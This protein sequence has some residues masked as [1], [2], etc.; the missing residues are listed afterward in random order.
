MESITPLLTYAL[1]LSIAAVI[2]GPGIAALVGQSLGGGFRV[3]MVMLVGI[4]IGDI[5]YLSVA[6]AGLAAVA[7]VFADAFIAVKILGG[8]YLFYLAYKFCRS[9]AGLTQVHREKGHGAAR[10]F[11]GGIAVTLSNPKPI[12]FYLALLPTLVDLET[13]GLLTWAKLSVLT[14]LVLF[15]TLTPYAFLAAKARGMMKSPTAL[16]R[17]NRVAGGVIGAAG[18]VILGQTVTEIARRT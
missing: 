12:V 18:A 14:F 10:A 13:I 16:Q 3:A 4:A 11:F 6:I 17:L 15:A 2:P 7:R 5:I 1:A 8:L 9:E